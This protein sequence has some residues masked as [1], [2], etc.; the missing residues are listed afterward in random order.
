[1][2]MKTISSKKYL[3]LLLFHVALLGP[4]FCGKI[5]VWPTEGSH[6]LNMNVMVQELIRRG[7]SFTILVSN[8]TLFI[9]PRP[10][11]TEKF[12]IYNVPFEKDLPETLLNDIVDLWL[13]NRPTI[14][15]FWQFF[16]ELGRLSVSWQEMN[17]M[18][19]DAVLTNQEMMARLQGS[20]FDLLLSDA[21]TPCGELLALKL[22]IPFVYSLRFSPAF[23]LERHCGKIPA[24]PSYTP[25]ALSELTDRMSFGERVKN[26]LSYH[27]Q[28]YVFQSYW[29]HWDNYCSKVLADN[30]HWLNMEHILQELV[31]RGHEVTVLLPSCFLIVNPTQPS[32]FQFEVIEVPITKKEM[33]DF[34]D[35]M[36]YFFFNEERELPIWKSTYKIAQMVLQMKNITKVICDGVVKNETL[37]E[38]LRASAF[39]VLLADPLFPSGELVAEKLGIPFVYTFRFSMGNTVERLCGTLPAPPSYVPTTL[40]SLTDRMTFWQRLKNILGYALHDFMFHYVLWTSWD[41]YYSEVL[42]RPTTL[43]ETMGKAEIWLIRTYWDFEFPRPFLPNFEFVGGLHCQPAK[44]LPKEMEEFVQSSGEHGIIVFTLGSMVHSLSDEKSNVIAKALSQLPQKVLWRYKGKKPET[45]GS[46]TRIFDWIPQNDLL[47][48]PLTKA[49]ITHGGTNGLYEAIYHGIPMVGIPMFAD[50]HDNLAHMVA[51]G[52][53]VQVD[54]NTV[55]TQDLVDALNTVIYNSTY[56]EN[57]LKLSKIQHDQPVKPLDRAVFWIE[58]VMRHKGAKHLRPAAHHL[59]W[60]Q[61]HSLDVLA[62]LFTCTATIV[63][64]LFKCC[65]CCCRRCGRIAKR[66]KE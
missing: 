2:A 7:H 58:F 54:F 19:C 35:K 59:T 12:E 37:M 33:T 6:W 8:A 60:Y 9:E 28:D 29:G 41:Q 43:C 31:A 20:G 47:G 11:T 46:N 56:K 55:K 23:T 30:S 21:V 44:P 51:K 42:G 4:V 48:H 5:L 45:L 22:D 16:K 50:Q 63:F 38:R 61:Y 10:K 36:F 32:P 1:M 62:F 3:Q 27:L 65:L 26:F 34:M 14:L 39:N 40:T 25:A 52:A 17:K 53:A 66:K 64:I 49:F 24:P 15:T 57:A 13:N 18:M